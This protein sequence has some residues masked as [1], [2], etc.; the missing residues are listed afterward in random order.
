M[1][2]IK[3][4][5]IVDGL[6]KWVV[7]D[8]LSQT[9]KSKTWLYEATYNLSTP[10]F[11]VYDKLVELITRGANN[12]RRIE[13]RLMF[14]PSRAEF[15]TIHVHMPQE[16]PLGGNYIGMGIG[17]NPPSGTTTQFGG[18]H[19][20]VF[21]STYDIICTSNNQM[22]VIL[23][24]ELMKRLFVAGTD[25]LDSQLVNY[26]FSGK[27]LMYD[28]TLMPD[29]FFKA[30]TIS[31][32]DDIK[33]PTILGRTS[34]IVD[35]SANGYFSEFEIP[36]YDIIFSVDEGQGTIS[37]KINDEIIESGDEIN[38]QQI[39][40]F[41]ATPATNYVV[42]SW[43]I[44][45]VSSTETGNSLSITVT[46][47]TDVVVNFRITVFEITF[48]QPLNGVLTA[49]LDGDLIESGDFVDEGSEV[50]MNV[51]VEEGYMVVDWSVNLESESVNTSTLTI[52]NINED[53]NI[54]V[55]IQIQ[56]D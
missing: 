28:T 35:I 4:K 18:I 49:T 41:T 43:V 2:V 52:S 16:E 50:V 42:D 51:V 36:A 14:D 8:Y 1:V 46:E 53:K 48:E 10:N 38:E 3:I 31:V 24:Y 54:S 19:E 12:A 21:Q 22:E 33:V 13:T 47:T 55:E 34:D 44:N 15:P 30:F 7:S 39:V 5:N 6:L 40:V 9:D 32:I 20:K 29:I 45:G 37:A 17:N 25:T 11:N 27:E 56:G 26:N 23:I